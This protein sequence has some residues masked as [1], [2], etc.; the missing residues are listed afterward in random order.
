M[1]CCCWVLEIFCNSGVSI[2]QLQS[3]QSSL[4]RNLL[5]KKKRSVYHDAVAII[6]MKCCKMFVPVRGP[7]S[8][9]LLNSLHVPSYVLSLLTRILSYFT[10]NSG[11]DES[12][13]RPIHDLIIP[14]GGVVCS[15]GQSAWRVRS[16]ESRIT[17]DLEIDIPHICCS[18]QW[19]LDTSAE[20]QQTVSEH[21]PIWDPI[22]QHW[23]FEPS[24]VLNFVYSKTSMM[25]E[26]AIV[27]LHMA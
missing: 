3:N 1:L 4:C 16:S 20:G 17:L 22:V 13:Q 5:K 11:V 23:T 15:F 18:C 27:I 7:P 26:R 8:I 10:Q 25:R 9:H 24:Y 2:V 19:T 6:P 21:D 12:H 14:R